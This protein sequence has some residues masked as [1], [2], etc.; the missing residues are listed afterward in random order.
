MLKATTPTP[1]FLGALHTTMLL[2]TAVASASAP[3]NE[4]TIPTMSPAASSSPCTVT[5]VPPDKTPLLGDKERMSDGASY[6]NTK[7]LLPASCSESAPRMVK[8]TVPAE[9]TGARH[10]SDVE[11]T[12]LAGA[13]ALFPNRHIVSPAPKF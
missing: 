7:L 4:H 1:A 2:L 11:D 5:S 8:P 6:S 9:C 3:P 10:T 13:T 12:I